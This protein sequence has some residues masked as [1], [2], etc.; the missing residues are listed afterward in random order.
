MFGFLGSFVLGK[1]RMIAIGAVAVGVAFGLGYY[2]G[3]IIAAEKIRVEMLQQRE[4]YVQEKIA[5]HMVLVDKQRAIEVAHE[6]DKEQIQVVFRD[7]IKEVPVVV[8]RTQ[9]IM[10]KVPVEKIKYVT[11][12]QKTVVEVP[13]QISCDL[14]PD[15]VTLWNMANSGESE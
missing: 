11:K 15:G 6:K 14:P 2:K 9:K 1:I 8:T 3:S 5:E 7:I 13:V 10:V 4:I 12:T